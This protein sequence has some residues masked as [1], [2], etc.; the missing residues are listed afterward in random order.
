[1]VPENNPAIEVAVGTTFKVAPGFVV[2]TPRL[3]LEV[4]ILSV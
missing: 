2:P 3:P 1:V 4:I